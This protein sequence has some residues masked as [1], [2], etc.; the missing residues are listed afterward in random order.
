MSHAPERAAH[1]R[2]LAKRYLNLAASSENPN[3]YLR[4]AVQYNALAEAERLII[5]GEIGPSLAPA[6]FPVPFPRWGQRLFRRKSTV[7]C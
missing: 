1:Y 6:H 2:D 4:I 7:P 3:H 5:P